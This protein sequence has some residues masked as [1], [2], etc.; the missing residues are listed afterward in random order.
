MW[1]VP[2]HC[3]CCHAW[4]VGLELYNK[5]GRAIVLVRVDYCSE[6]ITWPWQLLLIKRINC[7]HL[8]T[9]QRFSPLWRGACRQMWYWIWE[10]Y[11]LTQRQHRVHWQSHWGKLEKKRS[12]NQTPQWHTSSNK[13]TPPN[14]AIPFGG[15]FLSNHH[16]IPQEEVSKD[17]PSMA[18][19]SAL[20]AR[21]L[22]WFS[23][24]WTVMWGMWDEISHFLPKLLLFIVFCESNS[25][26]NKTLAYV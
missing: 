1:K 13:T 15:H 16:S 25:S 14:S 11:I 9:V 19:A 24:L 12:Q 20:A 4:A 21:F 22:P 17:H 6:E 18:S 26:P 2:T 3:R 5:V 10:F 23:H 7:G 8:L